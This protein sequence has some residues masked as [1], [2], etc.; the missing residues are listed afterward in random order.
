MKV[1]QQND[2]VAAVTA[3]LAFTSERSRGGMLRLGLVDHAAELLLGVV[4]E[5]HGVTVD[6]ARDVFSHQVSKT[7]LPLLRNAEQPG[8]LPS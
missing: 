6:M 4:A 5:Q 3:L 1:H 2:L 8:S 7:L